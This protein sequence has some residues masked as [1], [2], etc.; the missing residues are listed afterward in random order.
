M[1][2]HVAGGE[3]NGSSLAV[4]NILNQIHYKRRVTTVRTNGDKSPMSILAQD[5]ARQRRIPTTTTGHPKMVI[6]AWN[7]AGEDLSALM[8]P[9]E[10]AKRIWQEAMISEPP[11]TR[12]KE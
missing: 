10:E 5:W 11:P 4:T 6:V 1:M 12:S 3:I 9:R 7:P 8:T 2:I